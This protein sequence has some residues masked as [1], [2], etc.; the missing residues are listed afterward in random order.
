MKP[1]ACIFALLALALVAAATPDRPNDSPKKDAPPT[2]IAKCQ[3]GKV[4]QE[5][6]KFT[7]S[8]NDSWTADGEIAA[9]GKTVRL[10]WF[11][12]P[13]GRAADGQY[14]IDGKGE[15]RGVWMWQ[16]EA[17]YDIDERITNGNGEWLHKVQ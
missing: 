10:T 8:G 16:D 12:L 15:M 4:T 14:K 5:G 3:F 1:I 13:E 2:L 17:E 11:K 6:S 9:D 7:I